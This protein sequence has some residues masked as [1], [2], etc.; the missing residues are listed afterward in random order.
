MANTFAKETLVAFNDT[1]EGFEDQLVISKSFR[2]MA[3]EGV[4]LERAY[5]TIWMPQPYIAQSFTGINQTSN[6]ARNYAQLTVPV[7]LSYSHS[8]PFTLSATELRDPLQ[9]KRIMKSAL[10]R[11]ASDINVDCS[12]LA[13]LQ[14]SIFVKRTTSASGFDDVAAIDT[15]MNR[16]GISMNDRKAFYNSADYNSMASNLAARG[17]LSGKAQN[18]YEKAYIGEVAGFDTYKLDYGYRLTAAAA[19]GVTITNTLPL[20]YTPSPTT[21]STDGLSK[22]NNDNRFQTVNL[23]VTSGTL[24]AGDAFTIGTGGTAV[25]EV[26]HMTKGDTGSLKTFRIVSQASGTAG[27]SG[28]YVITPPLISGTGATDPE[29][30]YKNVTQAATNGASLTFLNTVSTILNPFWQDEAMVIMPAK[31]EPDPNSGMAVTSLTTDSGIT[32]VM[33]KQ[34]QIGTLDTLYRLDAYYGLANLQPEM[35][36]VEAF[37]QT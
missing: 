29:L 23:A 27:G 8:V 13:A 19:T 6:F 25:N 20:Y 31:Y 17:T 33:A 18:A 7:S 28:N 5:N 32:I 4:A 12:N 36:G 10:Q 26:H 21:T 24:K 22:T 37:N 9:Q 34:A 30:Q 15:A 1:V 11:L 14:G 2:N 16:V 3:E 35:S